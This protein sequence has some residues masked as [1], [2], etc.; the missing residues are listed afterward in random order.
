VRV[1]FVYASACADSKVKNDLTFRVLLLTGK[2]I[3]I[4]FDSRFTA[5][6]FP[7]GEN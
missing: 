7:K 2:T 1:G 6:H 5:G 3:D 4:T